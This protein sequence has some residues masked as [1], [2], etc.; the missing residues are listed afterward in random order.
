MFGGVKIGK[1]G[2]LYAAHFRPWGEIRVFFRLFLTFLASFLQKWARFD[3]F[4]AV[5]GS[6]ENGLVQKCAD[7]KTC[8]KL[9]CG[10]YGVFLDRMNPVGFFAG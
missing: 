6:S 9:R 2:N 3:Q 7:E 8:P 10:E 4:C 5:L 1:Y